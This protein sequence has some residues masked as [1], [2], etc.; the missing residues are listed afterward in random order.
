MSRANPSLP[1]SLCLKRTERHESANIHGSTN[2]T[3]IYELADTAIH[4]PAKIHES[5]EILDAPGEITRTGEVFRKVWRLGAQS[6]DDYLKAR[7]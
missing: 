7:Y 2:Q 1:W 6:V 4:T 3:E 5:A